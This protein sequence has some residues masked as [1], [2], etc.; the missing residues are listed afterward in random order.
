MAPPLALQSELGQA[1]SRAAQCSW[2]VWPVNYY[3]KHPVEAGSN[4]QILWI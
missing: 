1:V 3:R 4:C 2:R